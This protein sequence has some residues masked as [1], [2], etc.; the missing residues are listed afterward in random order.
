MLRLRSLLHRVTAAFVGHRVLPLVELARWGFAHADDFLKRATVEFYERLRPALMVA[1][2]LHRQAAPARLAAS[3][4]PRESPRPRLAQVV[5]ALA[6][7]VPVY[8]AALRHALHLFAVC[9]RLAVPLKQAWSV[10]GS[11]AAALLSAGQSGLR[12]VLAAA[13]AVAR[14]SVGI[15]VRDFLGV[16]V[17]WLY[18]LAVFR[19]VQPVAQAGTAAT[20]LVRGA[21]RLVSPDA[22]DAIRDRLQSIRQSSAEE[23]A[24]IARGSANAGRPRRP[25]YRWAFHR[26]RQPAEEDKPDSRCTLGGGP[27]L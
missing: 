7:V 25:Q 18:Q 14:A 23:R 21:H 12:G 2:P 24:A 27:G 1:M 22:R 20:N 17:R 26:P 4:P 13:A 15:S 19:G 16:H 9:R 11:V 8:H 6:V 5:S 3:P 10:A